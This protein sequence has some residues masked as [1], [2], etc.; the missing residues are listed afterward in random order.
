M[1]YREVCP[2]PPVPVVFLDTLHHF[3]ATLDTVARATRDY[4][5][6]LRLYRAQGVFKPGG[7]CRPIR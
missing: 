2:Q 5:L 1:L 7:V 3:Q 4:N 6:D